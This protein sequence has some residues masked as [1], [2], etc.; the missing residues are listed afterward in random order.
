LGKF[1][2][3]IPAKHQARDVG[4]KTAERR[5]MRSRQAERTANRA[6]SKQ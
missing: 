6:I 4:E 3:Y 1:L 5:A 2:A